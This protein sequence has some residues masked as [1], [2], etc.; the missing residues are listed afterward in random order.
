MF[1]LKITILF[2]IIVTILFWIIPSLFFSQSLSNSLGFP[3]LEPM[4]FIKLLGMAF[5]ALCVGYI[6]GLR[7]IKN[8]RYPAI[9]ESADSRAAAGSQP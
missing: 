4:V 2:K 7:E 8:G 1:W 9:S 6:L 3:K 5:T